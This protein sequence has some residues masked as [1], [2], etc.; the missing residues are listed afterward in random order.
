MQTTTLTNLQLE[1]IKLY[2]TGMKRQELF[3]LK[4]VLAAFFARKAIKEA[5][6]VW[7]E[8]NLTNADMD[9]WLSTETL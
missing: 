2:S 3:E 4:D 1:I 8:Q 5:D 9:T 7:D 6:T